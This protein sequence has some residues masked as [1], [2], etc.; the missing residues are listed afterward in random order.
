MGIKIDLGRTHNKNKN[1]VIE[2]A[3]KEFHKEHLRINP[4]GGPISE[5]ELILITKNMNSRIRYRGLSPKEIMLQRD[6]ISHEN[7]PVSDSILSDEQY[8][9][10]KGNHP[11]ITTEPDQIF[12]LG[13]MVFLKSDVNKLRGREMYRVVDVFQRQG[14]NPENRKTV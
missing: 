7:K 6:Q 9:T 5:T 10:R 3:I 8:N 11:D 12:S 13:D 14:N 4:N 2:N 1:P